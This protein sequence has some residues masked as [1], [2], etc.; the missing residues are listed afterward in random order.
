MAPP[1]KQST[2]VN[3]TLAIQYRSF[4]ILILTW[5]VL[6]NL[7]SVIFCERQLSSYV[8]EEQ[9]DNKFTCWSELENALPT[10]NK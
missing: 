9:G 7:P 3:G 8:F 5:Y 6:R 1:E 4:K 10:A 2:L